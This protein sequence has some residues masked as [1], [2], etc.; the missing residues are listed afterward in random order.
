MIENQTLISMDECSS[1]TV[2]KIEAEMFFNSLND[3]SSIKEEEA[4]MEAG[5]EDLMDL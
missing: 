3:E 1:S 5:D 2:D 4:P